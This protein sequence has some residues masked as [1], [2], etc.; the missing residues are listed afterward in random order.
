MTSLNDWL[1]HLENAHSQEIQLGL[2]RI[3]TVAFR[4]G[5]LVWDAKIITVAGTNGKGSTVASLE[6]IYATAGFR[7]ATYT[8]PHLLRFNERIK[9]DCKPIS[10]HD[11]CQLFLAI[12]KERQEIVLSYFEMTTLAALLYF[13]SFVLDV[14]ILEVGLGGRMD[15][16]NIL[17]PDLCIITTVD[18][19][20]QLFL[21]ETI[22]AI[23]YE[24]AGILRANTPLIYA[25]TSPPLSVL[26]EIK[27][28]NT[29]LYQLGTHYSFNVSATEL[30]L[31]YLGNK[32]CFPRPNINLKAAS[33][34]V[35]AVL[36]LLPSLPVSMGKIAEAFM[37]VALLGRQQVIGSE[38]KT[39]FDVAH[40]PQAVQLLANFVQNHER[41]GRIFAVFSGLQD[42]DLC[43]LIK[44][45]KKWVDFWYPCLLT[46]KRAASESILLSAIHAENCHT[47]S[48]F[49]SPWVA[50]Q[51]VLQKIKPKDLI[52]V[53]GSFLTVGAILAKLEELK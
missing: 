49:S 33:A 23:G 41:K 31:T 40:N 17:E 5:L 21:G 3:K 28:L 2:T 30:Q 6:A 32:V 46:G 14:I 11:L 10:D 15:A 45:M 27:R 34:A 36:C 51:E 37:S 9:V 12:E 50:Y 39:I 7:V 8:S 43:G 48:C 38:I 22:E 26:G 44:P 42:K 4:L 24:K 47:S 18:L 29:P 13:K 19:D 53:Y 52:V 20:H 16:T 25:D 35:M 1:T